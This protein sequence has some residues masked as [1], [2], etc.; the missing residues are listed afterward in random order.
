MTD[1]AEMLDKLDMAFKGV[2]VSTLNQSVL[3]P[4]YFNQFVQEAIRAT[5]LLED[6]RLMEM[7]SQKLN[8]DRT[9]FVGR[10]LQPATEAVAAD[11]AKES[12]PAFHQNQLV[13]GE[14]LAETGI[15][16]QS[17]RRN[18]EKGDFQNTLISMFSANVGC[19]LEVFAL[20]S[21]PASTVYTAG[22]VLLQGTGGWLKKA[23]SS[24]IFYGSGAGKDFDGT[25]IEVTLQYLL[26]Q[27]PKQYMKNKADLV[28]YV[29]WAL[30][31]A[32]I[33]AII[34]RVGNMA[35]TALTGD[36]TPAYKGIPVKYASVLDDAEG[37][38][39]W[40]QVVILVNPDNLVY[41]IFEKVTIE[42]YR[43]PRERKTSFILTL[44]TDQHMENENVICI[45][46]TSK[47]KGSAF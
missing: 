45:G 40:G 39:S 16:D 36:F 10:I 30:Y 15:T 38:A 28:F 13:A 14:L 7:D 11:P 42:P 3:Q 47:V 5:V 43:L 9:G 19:D 31:D 32:Y 26:T 20:F 8:I 35:D 27:Y 1:N 24:Q 17:L 46:L 44:E 33:N 34:A 6:A 4:Q 21:N 12:V 23:A 18:I 29:P 2:T 25:N 41:G 37:N 22:S